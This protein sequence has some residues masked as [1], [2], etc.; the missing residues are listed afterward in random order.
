MDYITETGLKR[1]TLQELR[2]EIENG[3]KSVF[4]VSFETSVDSPNGLLIS[5]LALANSNFWQ[6]VEEVFNSLDPN[7]ATGTTLDSRAAINGVTRKPAYACTVSARL[8]TESTSATIP[9]GSVA[10]RQRGDLDF[11]LDEAVTINRASCNAL[12]IK[13]D[14]SAKNTDYVFQFTFGTVTL[15][16]STSQRNLAYLSSLILA[17]GGSTELVGENL[18]TLKVYNSDNSNVGITGSMPDDWDIQASEIGNFTA[19]SVGYQTCEIGELDNIPYSVEGW[20]GVYNEEAGTPGADA[21]SDSELRIRRAAVA[22]VQ[23]SKATDPAIEAAL[24]DVSGVSSAVVQSNRGFSTNADGVPGKSFVSLVI[25][26]SDADVA[27]CIF[28]NQPAGIQSYGNT[29]VNVTDK[30]GIE[31]QISFSRPEP[32]YLWVKFNYSV[33]D[34]ET[35]TGED[36]IKEA[37]V[38]WAE[39]QYTI[40]K[41][42]IPTRIPGGVYDRVPGIGMAVAHVA[43]TD[44]AEDAPEDG[45]YTWSEALPIGMFQYAVL[46]EDRITCIEE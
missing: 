45:D 26:G 33:Y 40:G 7:Q 39:S 29:T 21:E 17:A 36:A 8:Y 24:L 10:N 4:G 12:Y 37:M 44:S 32:K 2:T 5:Q 27:K 43:L 34:E 13:D 28:D 22:R 14:G 35:F 15:N 19:V 42:V 1:K 25:G 23:K 38:E 3:L 9:A 18:D 6:L 46:E 11:A 41:D 16:N 30:R 31:Q 20:D